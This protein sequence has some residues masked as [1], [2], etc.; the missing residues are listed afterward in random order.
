MKE[1]KKHV[2][3]YL[4]K[5][6]SWANQSE[7]KP[8]EVR[9][10]FHY[11]GNR[12]CANTGIKLP[13][14]VWDFRYQRVKLGVKRGSQVNTV[15]DQLEQRINDIYY[16]ALANGV[17]PDN[18]HILKELERGS[19]KE[20][21]DLFK[22]WL[23]FMETNKNNFSPGTTKSMMTAYN[24]F[25]EYTADK[26]IDFEDVTPELLAGYANFLLGVGNVNITV[27]GNIKRLKIFLNHARS[28]G[29][30]DNDSYKNFKWK[31]PKKR[32]FFLDWR[33]VKTLY[34]YQPAS[35]FERKVLDKWLFGTLTSLRFSDYNMLRKS[36]R[37]KVEFPGDDTVYQAVMLTQKKTTS[38]VT[39]PLTSEAV[40]IL[41][42]Y[43]DQPGD[44]ALPKV[45]SHVI[46]RHIKLIAR[47]AGITG[48]ETVE[49][50]RGSN[51]EMKDVDRCDLIG[52]HTGRK[53][54]ITHAL[55]MKI[56][57]KTVA[58]IA[59]HDEKTM[60]DFY[61]GVVD[62]GKFEKVMRDMRLT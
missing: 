32:I 33:E 60:N 38:P 15:L 11:D 20:R 42:R 44:L 55:D 54:W 23:K 4:K 8:R 29:M 17:K 53:S 37:R 31:V 16:G 19:G 3:F 9:F 61:A 10:F 7:T 36:Q 43:K 12:L 2:R 49:V 50:Y 58:E 26:R 52:T 41:D 62:R 27:H 47:K 35:E 51:R 25:K 59:G 1:I 21:P 45:G 5:R 28:R 30:H 57:G 14:D 18:H 34:D 48:K 46:N 56:A 22:E 40:A 39:V 6:N 24:R 13:L